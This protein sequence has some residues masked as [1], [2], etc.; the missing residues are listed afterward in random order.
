MTL[1]DS[2][3]ERMY[4]ELIDAVGM[5]NRE[6]FPQPNMTVT[7]YAQ[8]RGID[9]KIAYNALERAVRLG[10]LE[11]SEENVLVGNRWRV[12]YWKAKV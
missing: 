8:K 12:L 2:D 6:D 10:R 1:S 9:R 7:E 11:R 3:K 5:S 4:Q